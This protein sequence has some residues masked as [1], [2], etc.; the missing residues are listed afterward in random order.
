MSS[1][2]S[3]ISSLINRNKKKKKGPFSSPSVSNPPS[4][5]PQSRA[6]TPN[7]AQNTTNSP[8]DPQST[9]TSSN[10]VPSEAIDEPSDHS[11]AK[12]TALNV[13]KLALTSLSAVSDNV[14]VPGIKAAVDGLL[15]AIQ[16]IQVCGAASGIS[17]EVID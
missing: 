12:S 2:S 4:P 11:V 1:G 5:N 10:I 14:P 16:K 8:S 13:F 15:G 17:K 7:P 6:P 9:A 3:F